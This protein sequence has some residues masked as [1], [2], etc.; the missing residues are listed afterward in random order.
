MRQGEVEGVRLIQYRAQGGGSER[1]HPFA[2]TYEDACAHA[3][4]VHRALKLHP[5]V[6]PDVIVGHSGF[7]S[8]ALLPELTD[9]PIVNHFEFYYR[10]KGVDV[11]FRPDFPVEEETLLRAR[12]RNAMILT[13]LDTCAA[14]YAPT[15]F[16]RSLFPEAWRPKIEVLHDGIDTAFWKPRAPDAPRTV[17]GEPVPDG[18]RVV[19]YVSRGFESLRG[20]D[21]FV[22]AVRR[23]LDVR[24]DVLVVVV[25]QDRVVYG[26]DER[27][28]DG[29]SFKEWCLARDP[30]DPARVRFAGHRTPEE[31]AA[32]LAVSDLHVY[33]TVP[34]VL[35]WSML[36]AMA[37]GAVVLASDT[38]PVRDFVAHGENGLLAPFFDPD[39]FAAQALRVLDAPEA[40]RPLGE[41]ARRTILDRASLDVCHARLRALLERVAGRSAG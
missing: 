28:T 10:T 19:T 23:I 21:I 25:G 30:L 33:L 40:F 5:E 6:R 29:K 1:T 3:E 26:G 16:Q 2:R 24:K 36:N 17:L 4:G 39:A 14:G 7:G 12:F 35:S 15:P 13:D 11:D 18:T 34:F 37:C 22:K 27:F 31:L 8:T 20:F 41:A 38:A 9:A 32:I